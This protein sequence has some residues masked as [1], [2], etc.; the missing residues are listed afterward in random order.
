MSSKVGREIFFFIF[1]STLLNTMYE[2]I[3]F[4]QFLLNEWMG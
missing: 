4:A 2:K 1:I 3:V